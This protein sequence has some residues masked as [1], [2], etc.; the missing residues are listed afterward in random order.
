M[1]TNTVRTSSFSRWTRVAFSLLLLGTSA[2]ESER[3]DLREYQTAGQPT[4]EGTDD[5][6]RD[7]Q[8]RRTCIAFGATAALEAAYKR[9]GYGELDLSEEFLNYTGKMLW[10]TE[11][12]DIP[13]REP[14][15]VEPLG[16]NRVENQLAYTS[17]GN[18]VAW[19]LQ[20]SEGFHSV[21]ETQ[22]PYVPDDR[23]GYRRG[24]GT[25]FPEPGPTWETQRTANDFNLYPRHFMGNAPLDARL[26]DR[27]YSVR[28]AQV[29][30]GVGGRSCSELTPADFEAVLRGGR[31]IVID[32]DLRG[33]TGGASWAPIDPFDANGDGE[34]E[35]GEGVPDL[36]G[37]S[38]LLVGFDRSP[39]RSY[40]IVKNSWGRP[41]TADGDCAED[42]YT[43]MSYELLRNVY[44]AGYIE[45]VNP[46]RAWTDVAF[47]GRWDLSFDGERSTLDLYHLPGITNGI[48]RRY[49]DF[50]FY[51]DRRL[52]TL[53]DAAGNTFRVNGVITGN[54]LDLYYDVTTPNLRR[55]Q[56][57]GAHLT[58][59]RFANDFETMAGVENTVGRPSRGVYARRNYRG[60]GFLRDQ[61]PPQT[62]LPRDFLGDWNLNVDG[63]AYALS[64]TSLSPWT[65]LVPGR[66]AHAQLSGR[67]TPA[68]GG[69]TTV[70]QARVPLSDPASI[71]FG[72]TLADGSRRTV[73][74]RRFTTEREIFAGHAGGDLGF[75]AIRGAPGLTLTIV[76][77]A[78]GALFRRGS[79]VAEFAAEVTAADPLAIEWE[80]NLA[81]PI[82]SGPRVRAVD[83]PTGI[84]TIRATVTSSTGAVATDLVTIGILNDPPRLTVSSPSAGDTFEQT[85]VI[86]LSASTYDPN[87]LAPVPDANVSWWL[88][89]SL[90][91][92]GHVASYRATLLTPGTHQLRVTAS[93]GEASTEQ[94]VQFSVTAGTPGT[95]ARPAALITAPAA[96]SIALAD[97]FDATTGRFQAVVALCGHGLDPEDGILLG[98]RLSWSVRGPEDLTYRVLGPSSGCLNARLPSVYADRNTPY[99]VRLVATDRDG[100]TSLPASIRLEVSGLF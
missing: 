40:F 32:L 23:T 93:D 10:L 35:P 79:E 7:Q 97:Q 20:L 59:H 37:H 31:E 47:V 21:E 2:C 8:N 25:P 56:L 92:T 73:G 44:S 68:S 30:C 60:E 33:D 95:N 43:C 17:G 63:I 26:S 1:V 11:N 24:A 74:G 9:A 54:R 53:V 27:Y 19:L 39:E 42:G 3:V 57:R 4:Y 5:V 70:V 6:I 86:P 67:M 18:G 76:A 71:G 50:P 38:V 72:A 91:A 41:S 80:S 94:E 28:S 13:G 16:P 49:T 78:D 61:V 81:G 58:L 90:V 87:D 98:S 89:G 45:E 64:F 96:G 34:I 85:Q 65:I 69:S 100:A 66:G 48:L 51:E 77:P 82:G 99:D 15:A 14:P 52:G 84:H 29:M 36:G 55:D 83:L 75:Y 46:P 12:W 88:D 62:F 22:M